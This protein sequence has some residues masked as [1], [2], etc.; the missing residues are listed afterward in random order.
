M[1]FALATRTVWAGIVFL[2]FGALALW[3]GPEDRGNATQMA[4]GYFP[5]LLGYALFIVGFLL[6]AQGLR[7]VTRDEGSERL[8]LRPFLAL[9]AVLAFALLLERAGLVIATFALL[10]IGGRAARD[11]TL[12]QFVVL[13]VVLYALMFAIFVWG[14]GLPVSLWPA[15]AA[16]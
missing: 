11:L 16:T 2:G 12:R 10:V 8:S 13:A 3:L 7:A 4:A 14:L 9:A 15:F 5:A 6:I 1:T